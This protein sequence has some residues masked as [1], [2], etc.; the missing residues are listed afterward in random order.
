[1]TR[2]ISTGW[3]TLAGLIGS[4]ALLSV[5]S[6]SGIACAL[7][8]VA[9]V[10]WLLALDRAGTALA[11]LRNGWL[12]SV[13]FVLAVFFWFASAIASYTGTGSWLGLLALAIA[14]PLLQP[15]LIAFAL[16]R[17]AVGRRH[18]ALLRAL[19]GAATWVAAEWL[20][21]KLF[22]DTLGHGLYPSPQLRQFA[23]LGGAAGITFVLICANEAV[24]HAIARRSA[25]LRALA[26]PLTV[27]AGL[28]LLMW[29][30]G[31]W[32]L[33]TL[34]APPADG[35]Q[36]LRVGLI[37]ANIVDYE[38][39]RREKGTYAVVREV[40]DTHFAMSG[41]AVN[42]QRVDA[43]VWSETVYPTTYGHPKSE[44]GDRKSVV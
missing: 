26:K 44:D 13:A 8:F 10:P 18:G 2:L 3:R 4:A 23:D 39:L 16:V 22:D 36:S 33:T 11:V 12:M 28:A 17:H 19:A 35:N 25:G 24:A 38:R 31:A 7:G 1:M 20:L 15:Q 5:Y 37:Q 34:Q 42:R 40:L 32:R 30:Y 6:R 21:P 9:L 29:I 27:A 43:L 14:A 41:E